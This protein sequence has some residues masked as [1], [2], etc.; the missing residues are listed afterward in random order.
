MQSVVYNTVSLPICCVFRHFI[1]LNF[2][3]VRIEK[4]K[5]REQNKGF[6]LVLR[7]SVEREEMKKRNGCSHIGYK[8]PFN[9]LSNGAGN[10]KK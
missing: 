1:S 3:Q 7:I 2:Y 4:D 9:V 8:F 5:E 10:L 6:F